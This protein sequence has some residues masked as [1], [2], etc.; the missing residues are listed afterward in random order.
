MR[1]L[2]VP[3]LILLLAV[4]LPL[5][6]VG[7]FALQS[8]LYSHLILIP[9]ISVYLLWLKRSHFQ[10]WER[11]AP[12]AWV[13]AF[14]ALSLIC[15]T[16]CIL[17]LN[18]SEPSSPQDLLA[19][20]VYALAFFTA[21][22][23]CLFLD[24]RV[25]PSTIFPIGFLFLMAP[26]PVVIETALENFLQHAS[27]VVAHGIFSLVG[28]PVLREGT[29][30]HLPDFNMEVAPECS[31]INSTLVLFI[32]SLVAGQLFLRS[33]WKRGI[34]ALVVLPIALLRNGVR[35]FTIGELCV[36]VGPHMINSYIHRHGGPIFFA[37][38]LV[39][40]ILILLS[41]LKSDRS[42]AQKIKP[43]VPS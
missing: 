40:F 9:L 23:A 42:A 43:S 1:N 18:S 4:S 16:G 29:Y 11:P 6:Q 27:A 2:T 7:R 26:F 34:L 15:L 21:G 14:S 22:W 30:F 31:G 5:Y 25:L 13:V 24:A 36:H 19:L 35:I 28:T 20:E 8:H 32:V 10:V 12:R 17:M 37:A 3:A 39:P 38:S 33:P 41:L